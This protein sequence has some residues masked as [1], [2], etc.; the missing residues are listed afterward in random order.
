MSKVL[1]MIKTWIKRADQATQ[2]RNPDL[3]YGT[4]E[5]MTASEAVRKIKAQRVT[6]DGKLY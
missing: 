6:I 2:P 5:T 4:A 3:E 1:T